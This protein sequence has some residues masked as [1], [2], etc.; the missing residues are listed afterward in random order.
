MAIEIY[1]DDKSFTKKEYADT[2]YA[3]SSFAKNHDYEADGAKVVLVTPKPSCGELERVQRDGIEED[4]LGNTVQKWKVEPMFSE[5]TND[6]DVLVTKA[7]QEADY[8]QKKFKDTVPTVI[9]MR[10]AR[11]ALLDAGLLPTVDAAIANGTDEALKIEWEYATECKRE[12]ESLVAMATAL[13]MSELDL[14]N[15]FIA[16]STL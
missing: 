11:L 10:Q 13:G 5:Y 9:T 2:Y 14:D 16:G 4:A 15:L 1:R 8:I 6:E 3:G 12:W 7:E